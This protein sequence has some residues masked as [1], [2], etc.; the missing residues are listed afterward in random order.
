MIFT[1]G[2]PRIETEESRA[3]AREL[4]KTARMNFVRQMLTKPQVAF[5]DMKKATADFFYDPDH[6]RIDEVAEMSLAVIRRPGVQERER[7]AAFRQ[8]ERGRSNYAS[9]DL[10]KIT[11]PTY[12]IHGR[13]ERFF[14]PKEV[15][16]IL[17]ECAM[18]VA[19]S[20]SD[21]CATFLS[22]CGHW[23]QM[24]RAKTFNA[25]ALG[26]LERVEKIGKG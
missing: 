15:A 7:E 21:C 26:F 20:V 22:S 12:L 10:A 23:P 14:Y 2:E 24:E 5:K 1:G 6:P 11:A 9:S 18:K 3:V 19:L 17:L 16:T 8:V 4:G 13:D 25:L